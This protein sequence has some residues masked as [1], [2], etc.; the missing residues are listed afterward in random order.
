MLLLGDAA[1]LMAQ[2]DD[3]RP[4]AYLHDAGDFERTLLIMRAWL[5]EN[6]DVTVVPGHDPELWP[7]LPAVFE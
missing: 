5:A 6:P 7:T 2:L 3:P 1:H 4:Q